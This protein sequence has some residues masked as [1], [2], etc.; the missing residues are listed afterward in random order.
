MSVDSMRQ[1]ANEAIIIRLDFAPSNVT[2]QSGT[3]QRRFGKGTYKTPELKTVEGHY[4][5]CL[6]PHT[7]PKP[8]D[9][10]LCLWIDFVWPWR[11]SEPKKNTLAG[12]KYKDT[13]PDLE[14]MEKTLID[15][16]ERC[17]F[18]HND[19]QIASKCTTKRWG[20][21]PGITIQLM[22]AEQL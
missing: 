4:A 9:G 22:K 15:M 18:F 17:R 12:R 13:Q 3:R 8:L 11:K 10:P 14:N 19:A 7:P 20:D 5:A 16:M 6:I 2:Y 21:Y 1:A